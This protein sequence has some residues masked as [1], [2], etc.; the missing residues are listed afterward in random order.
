MSA[1]AVGRRPQIERGTTALNQANRAFQLISACN[2]AITH[3]TSTEDI[4]HTAC[5]NLVDIGGYGFALFAV[6][7][8]HAIQRLQT[9]CPCRRSA[10][11]AWRR[12]RV[13]SS[14]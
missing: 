5:P 4:L 11:R 2:Q 8:D 7:S 13:V 1:D 14:R 9:I 3:A 6:R 10:L 12:G